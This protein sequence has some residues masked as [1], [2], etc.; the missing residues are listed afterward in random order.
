MVFVQ[1]YWFTQNKNSK[2]DN[3][4]LPCYS[5]FYEPLLVGAGGSPFLAKKEKKCRLNLKKMIIK[6]PKSVQNPQNIW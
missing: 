5:L 1:G 2:A 3:R 6:Y 4:G